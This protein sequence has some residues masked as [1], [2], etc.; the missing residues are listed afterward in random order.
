MTA[1]DTAIVQANIGGGVKTVNIV[2]I[3]GS[4]NRTWF[5]GVLLC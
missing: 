1:G 5:Q 3:S 4:V 2:A